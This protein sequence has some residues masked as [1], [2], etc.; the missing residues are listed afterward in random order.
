VAVLVFAYWCRRGCTAVSGGAIDS[1]QLQ[2]AA[3]SIPD[4]GQG[5]DP[6]M[7]FMLYDTKTADSSQFKYS[8]RFQLPKK[9]GIVAPAHI[10]V[11]INLDKDHSA[12]YNPHKVTVEITSLTASRVAGTFSGEF[13]S[14]PDTPNVPKPHIVVTD[15]KF[16][17]PFST[18]NVRP[19]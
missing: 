6:K 13:D 2:N 4:E 19:F 11:Y 5:S 1:L 7:G 12:V 15:G 18:S 14:S 16:D 10:N 3:F 9:T 17:L 8:L